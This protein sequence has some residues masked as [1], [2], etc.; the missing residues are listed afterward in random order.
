MH[1][2]SPDPGCAPEYF[3]LRL[4][5]EYKIIVVISN[6]FAPTVIDFILVSQMTSLTHGCD[7]YHFVTE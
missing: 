3:S 1:A 7:D 2:L 6:G 5:T 4:F